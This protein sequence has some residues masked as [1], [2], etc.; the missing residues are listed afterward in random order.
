[1]KYE[2]GLASG[3]GIESRMV[4]SA[5][6]VEAALGEA[7]ADDRPRLVEVPVQPGMSLF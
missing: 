7:I 2:A 6:E 3:Y 1:M 4:K 5:D